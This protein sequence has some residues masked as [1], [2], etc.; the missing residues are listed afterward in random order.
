MKKVIKF[1]SLGLSL[2]LAVSF[3]FTVSA[4]TVVKPKK[5]TLS[6]SAVTVY[7]N[8]KITLSVKSVSPKK[9]SASVKW[10][11]SDNSIVTVSSKGK[12]T[13]NN[14]GTATVTAVSKYNS[15]VKSKCKITVVPYNNTFPN[16]K[17]RMVTTELD[18][19]LNVYSSTDKNA[20]KSAEENQKKKEK[21]LGKN[22]TAVISSYTELKSYKKYV[23]NNFINYSQILNQ[24]NKYKKSYF[25][26]RVLVCNNAMYWDHS[27]RYSYNVSG[28]ETKVSKVTGKV[29][30]VINVTKTSLMKP[31]YAYTSDC[32]YYYNMVFVSFDKNDIPEVEG[33]KVKFK[34]VM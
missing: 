28:V 17:N 1:V 34:T 24:L 19:S 12:I 10:K 4:K 33:Y 11:S 7:K 30:A 13:A 27:N 29:T 22:E 25:K 21:Q 26:T 8:E 18:K 16:Y 23:K 9:A 5:I 31:D 32:S 2:L 3:C 15:K 6:S 20:V 14:Y